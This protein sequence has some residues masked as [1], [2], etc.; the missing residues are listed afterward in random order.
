MRQKKEHYRQKLPNYQQPGQWYFV[1]VILEGAIPKRAIAMYSMKLM[2]A[3]SHYKYILAQQNSLGKE[4]DFPK[5]M[6]FADKTTE[7]IEL[8]NSMSQNSKSQEALS[9]EDFDKPIDI[10]SIKSEK[11]IMK[12]SLSQS[13][14][15]ELIQAKRAY[16][17]ALKKHRLAIDKLLHQSVEPLVSLTKPANL[18]IIKNALRFWEGKKLKTHAWCIM[19]NHF[20]WVLTVLEKDEEGKPVYL[21]D[22]LHSVKQFTAKKINKLENRTGQ[23]WAHE[24]FETTIKNHQH[25]VNVF[26]YVVNNPVT[27][28][29]T[30]N[31]LDWPGTC[32]EDM[33]L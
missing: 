18:E 25:F 20:H 10:G 11:N 22:I 7:S 19:S 33:N 24:S 12:N 15:P 28:G 17:L 16:Y 26:N 29:L 8:G 9:G 3:K 5:S 13:D 32:S 23:F 1:T 14:S 2:L 27:A 31:G 6:E 30:K 21:E 4:M